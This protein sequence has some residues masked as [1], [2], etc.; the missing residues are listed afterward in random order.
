[1]R[2]IYPANTRF[3]SERANT[4]QI[5]NTC[6]AL[7]C[8]GAE[9]HLVVRR[10]DARP[11]EECLGFYGLAP[12][13]NLHVHR[14]R[15][16]NAHRHPRLWDR[17]F[18][19]LCLLEIARLCAK[20]GPRVI[21]SREIGFAKLLLGLAPLLR[22]KLIFESHDI[23]Y[24]TIRHFGELIASDRTFDE[25]HQRRVLRKEEYL[26]RRVHGVVTVTEQLR[27][28]I[29]EQFQPNG[30]TRVIRN[31]V[32]LDAPPRSVDVSKPLARIV[33][34][35][36]VYLWK[37]VG[38]LVDAMREVD[39]GELLVLGGL[40]YEE[41]L[42]KLEAYAREQGVA[43]R[44]QFPGNVPPHR[45]NEH[46]SRADV[47]VLP[48]TD[49]LAS[50]Y[51]TCPLKMLQYMACGVPIVATRLPAVSEVLQHNRNALLV[52]PDNPGE[53]AA[54]IRR[55][56]AD[57]PF[58]DQLA[59]QARADVQQFGWANRAQR[60]LALAEEVAAGGVT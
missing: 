38:T 25:A 7:A 32:D 14:L 57:R 36:Q 12:H 15:A 59:A 41:D 8:A 53:L 18:Q 9:V 47:A 6:H 40:P 3:P 21:Y 49:T 29:Q 56:I 17:S 33:Y 23:G 10:M 34:T 42:A 24:L 45:V 55:L 46:L 54:A 1:M 50:R 44:V 16:L 37:G 51:F 48:L 2:I 5:T 31:G 19:F 22:A 20:P 28:I 35:G 58:A 30:T 52:Q 39:N 27:R 26:Y 13:P 60:V 4:I 43:D 11:E